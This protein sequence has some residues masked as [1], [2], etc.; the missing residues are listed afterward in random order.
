M[1]IGYIMTEKI[2]FNR[3]TENKSYQILYVQEINLITAE[4]TY[5]KDDKIN[6]M[7]KS[8]VINRVIDDL[9]KVNLVKKMKFWIAK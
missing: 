5:S 7:G 4:I 9:I 3:V 2:I 1:S 6:K 8:K